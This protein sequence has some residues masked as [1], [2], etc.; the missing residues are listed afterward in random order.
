MNIA[1]MVFPGFWFGQS[2]EEEAI[3][4]D[5]DNARYHNSRGVILRELG[6]PEEAVKE[7]KKAIKL[8][9]DEG[10][11]HASLS[12]ALHSLGRKEKA[13]EEMKM[14][15]DLDPRNAYHYEEIMKEWNE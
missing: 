6:R 4:L 3:R 1:R 12:M 7:S 5:P 10:N 15:I 14:A 9:F 8:D 13:I 2:S 11:Y